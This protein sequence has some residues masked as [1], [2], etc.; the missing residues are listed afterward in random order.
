VRHGE[1]DWNA[2]GVLQGWTD[3]PLNDRGRAQARALARELA[4]AGF[5]EVCA[6]PLRRCLET[7]QILTE[8]WGLATPRV[9]EGLKERHFGSFQG[10][11][12]AELAILHPGL[13]EE[14]VRRNPACHF[15]AGESLDHFADRVI[16][17]LEEIA[18]RNLG[19]WALVITHGWVMDVITRHARGL[20]RTAVLGMKRKNGEALWL[21]PGSRAPLVETT[22]PP[23]VPAVG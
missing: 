10:M 11:A 2:T 1:T 23:L 16:A 5:A 18:G 7:A 15:D 4:G 19:R 22:P 3:V 14:I 6:S 21:A 13:H 20:P 17:A 8:A 12:K 9:Y